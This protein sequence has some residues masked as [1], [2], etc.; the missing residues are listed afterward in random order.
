MSTSNRVSNPWD[1]YL[2]SVAALPTEKQKQLMK[3]GSKWTFT[4]MRG[5]LRLAYIDEWGPVNFE[6]CRAIG[7]HEWKEIGLDELKP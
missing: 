1:R 4:T 7:T 2:A 5:R 3:P 6:D